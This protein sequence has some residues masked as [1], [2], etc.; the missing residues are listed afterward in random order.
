MKKFKLSVIVAVYNVENYI[1]DCL[2]SFFDANPNPDT[3]QLVIVNDG[4]TD[5][6]RQLINHFEQ[7]NNVVI[8]D[9]PNGGLSSARNSGLDFVLGNTEYVSFLDADDLLSVE[10]FNEF[11]HVEELFKP[12][13]IEFNANYFSNWRTVKFDVSLGT[14][15]LT[16]FNEVLFNEIVTKGMWF[17]WSRIYKSSLFE[18]FRFPN[19]RRYEDMILIPTLYANSK[20][21]YSSDKVL[22]LY[23]DNDQGITRNGKLSDIEDVL[24]AVQVFSRLDLSPSLNAKFKSNA[25]NV[26]LAILGSM[27]Y[28]I[29]HWPC[30][31]K[32]AD[33][34]KI[35]L[36]FMYFKYIRF[37]LL[38]PIK[39]II[40]DISKF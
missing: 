36:T 4:S 30:L 25:S 26:I 6:S 13:I 16:R 10:Y 2:Q 7:Y 9:K 27:P 11:Y 3:I 37:R 18:E 17:A 12:D 33:D 24:F 15:N 20:S 38:S 32:V 28:N 14:G 21:I 29:E 19:G 8:I 39:S 1:V 35:S 31:K 40:K 5:N 34:F 23:R 22:Y